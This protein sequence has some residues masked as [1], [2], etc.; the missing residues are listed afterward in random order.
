MNLI[1]KGI[2]YSIPEQWKELLPEEVLNNKFPLGVFISS[3]GYNPKYFKKLCLKKE[4]F[5]LWYD[6]KIQRTLANNLNAQ[7][8][9]EDHYRK[10][11]ETNSRKYG[12]PQPNMISEAE[13]KERLRGSMLEPLYPIKNLKGTHKM[14]CLLCKREV[15]IRFWK[16]SNGWTSC[17]FCN[18]NSSIFERQL[19]DFIS[20]FTEVIPHYRQGFKNTPLDKKEI[21][22]FLPNLNVGIEVNGILSHNSTHNII[23]EY[24]GT[25]DI[26]KPRDYHLKKTEYA[27]KNGIYLIHI[28]E[29]EPYRSKTLNFI[30]RVITNS[31]LSFPES[32]PDKFKLRR[33]LYP[34]KITFE[35]YS[36]R[37]EE[38]KWNTT[39]KGVPVLDGGLITY[40][41]GLWI[42]T[43][44]D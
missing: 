33:D 24:R 30:K 17:P 9:T 31:H 15:E 27:L 8:V 4:D 43:K 42:Y 11:E 34:F 26:P 38:E 1:Y 2:K 44:N 16:T 29:H 41:S 3:I 32:L 18:R 37:Y 22:I 7:K 19:I 14:R 5:K 28:W 12:Y 40:T 35:G 23:S 13:I 6:S 10:R 39:R 25:A 21:D 36:V 20:K